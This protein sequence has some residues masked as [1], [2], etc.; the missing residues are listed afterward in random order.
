MKALWS[1]HVEPETFWKRHQRNPK[2]QRWLWEHSGTSK[3]AAIAIAK[4]RQR[5]QA[6]LLIHGGQWPVRMTSRLVRCKII[7]HDFLRV[8]ISKADFQRVWQCLFMGPHTNRSV[9]RKKNKK[10]K[11]SRSRSH[12][13]YSQKVIP[14]IPRHSMYAIHWPLEP[15][16]CR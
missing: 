7:Q 2:L 10:K 15:P 11:T 3:L 12:L 14:L 6:M 1:P 8:G 13:G 4:L 5:H 16:Q 9:P